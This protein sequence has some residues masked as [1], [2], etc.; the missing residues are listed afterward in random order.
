VLAQ[1]RLALLLRCADAIHSAR[2]EAGLAEAIV[3]AAVTGT[4]FANAALLRASTQVDQLALLA[5]RGQVFVGPASCRSDRLEAGPTGPRL[6]RSPLQQAAAGTPAR[7]TWREEYAPAAVSI[8]ELGIQEALCI[9]IL[10][11]GS[12]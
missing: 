1:E 5:H 8:V 12:V 9:P 2:D 4:G 3:D 7:L 10:L 6:S 11:E